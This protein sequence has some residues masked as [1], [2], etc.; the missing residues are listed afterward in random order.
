ML[1]KLD[2]LRSFVVLGEERHFS[3]AAQRLNISQPSLSQQI[4]ALEGELGV[5]LVVRGS[6]PTELT[7]AGRRL[8]RDARGLLTQANTVMDRARQAAQGKV[9][10]LSIGFADDY[11]YGFLPRLL[12]DFSVAHP[13]V[14]LRSRVGL[15]GDLGEA[16]LDRNLDLA[17]VT[18]PLV[19]EIRGLRERALAPVE[20]RAVLPRGHRLAG[21]GTISLA[22][23][24]DERFV[25][26]TMAHWTGFFRQLARLFDHAGFE[27]TVVQ[28][29]NDPDL[30]CNVI[31]AGTGVGL[32]TAG[33]MAMRRD[34]LA[35][36]RLVEPDAAVAQVVVWRSDDDS[37]LV[38]DL[39]A[40]VDARAADDTGRVP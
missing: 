5:D 38:A 15:T 40:M 29:I 1:L 3:R 35:F 23:L 31:A 32:A 8:S 37:P 17:F 20:F 9:S 28:E 13:S 26:P 10:H 22:A 11:R 25:L 33:S 34:D 2:R 16:V 30:L 21:A 4:R 6:R 36:P 14:Y 19:P 18:P 7:E 27:P 24:R 12:A 39:L